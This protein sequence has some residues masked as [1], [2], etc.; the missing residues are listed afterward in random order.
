MQHTH[1]QYTIDIE[2]DRRDQIMGRFETNHF[3]ALLYLQFRMFIKLTTQSES[4][5]GITYL[6]LLLYYYVVQFTQTT[7]ACTGNIMHKR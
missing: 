3:T 1:T 4:E 7:T 6:V 5:F 2:P